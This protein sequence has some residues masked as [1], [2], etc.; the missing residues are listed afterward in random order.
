MDIGIVE[1]LKIAEILF[2]FLGGTFLTN[3]FNKRWERTNKSSNILEE[4]YLKVISPIYRELKLKNN[5]KDT[6]IL[7]IGEIIYTNFHLLPEQLLEK[8]LTIDDNKSEFEKLVYDFYIILRNKLGY[9]RIK[10]S[11][12]I[13]EKEK[14]LAYQKVM[15]IIDRIFINIQSF[16]GLIMTIIL[17]AV[18]YIYPKFN[19]VSVFDVIRWI[20][21]LI[22]SL[23]M[24]IL[25]IIYFIKSDFKSKK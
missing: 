12:E 15:T 10:V 14:L 22:L 5:D 20:V 9:S 17:I 21:V 23:L 16:F 11:K 8:F 1:I 2:A 13:K 6:M 18:I 19:P 7:N 24:F 25:P 4:Q 3:I